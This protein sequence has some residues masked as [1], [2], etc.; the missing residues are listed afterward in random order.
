MLPTW[1]LKQAF[2]HR[3]QQLQPHGPKT[4]MESSLGQP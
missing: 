3:F 2:E 1:H 4:T